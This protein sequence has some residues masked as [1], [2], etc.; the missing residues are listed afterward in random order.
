MYISSF[1]RSLI[2]L[3]F[4]CEKPFALFVILFSTGAWREL[5]VA[6][7]GLTILVNLQYH[8]WTLITTISIFFIIKRR[9]RLISVIKEG[10]FLI[11]FVIFILLSTLWTAGQP[12]NTLQM[13]MRLL[14]TTIFGA[15]L[16]T[17]F[18]FREQTE[19]FVLAFGIQTISSILYVFGLPKYGIT[20]PGPNAGTWRGIFVNKNIL[21]RMMTLAAIFFLSKVFSTNKNRYILW[22]C[23][24]IAFQLILGTE[25]KTALVGLIFILLISPTHRILRWN[26]AI[27]IPLYLIVVLVSGSSSMFLAMNW[28]DALNSIDKS[29]DLNGRVPIWE[30][31]FDYIQQRPWLGYGYGGFWRGWKGEGSAHIWRT[32]TW[33]P[34][35]AHNGFVAIPMEVGFIGTAIFALSLLASFAKAVSW[36]RSVRTTESIWPMGCLIFWVLCNQTQDVLLLPHTTFWILYS[37]IS[38]TPVI[39]PVQNIDNDSNSLIRTKQN[40]RFT[41]QPVRRNY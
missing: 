7:D 1:T 9:N 38:F 36:I 5:L 22:I 11:F 30:M 20:P 40:H 32:I 41:N 17:R 39:M 35:H 24:F 23:F 33:K 12:S 28:N 37:T 21:G 26:S 6:V 10:K 34:S 16:A 13:G 15:Y 2:R 4:F 29:P 25:S 18:S 27:A 8:I 19:L 3:I 31:C 14:Q